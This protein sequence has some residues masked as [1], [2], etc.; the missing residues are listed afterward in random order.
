MQGVGQ[1][2]WIQEAAAAL[3]G[4]G[5]GPAVAPPCRM[6]RLGRRSRLA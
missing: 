5:L 1:E 6:L 3:P 2:V 4:P